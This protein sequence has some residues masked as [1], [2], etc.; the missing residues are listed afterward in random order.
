[1]KRN[2]YL[3]SQ[4]MLLLFV[5]GCMILAPSLGTAQTF[6]FEQLEQK[7]RSFSVII[8]MKMEIAFGVH[9]SEQTERHLGTIVSSDGLVLFDG[10]SLVND[11]ALS[12]F[13]GFSVK[14]TPTH[15]EITTMNDEKFDGEYLGVDRYTKL[16]FIRIKSNGAQFT[17]V[18]FETNYDF[19]VGHWIAL[20]MLLPEFISPNLAADVGMISVVIESPERFPLTVGF[21]ALQTASVLFDE[22]LQPVGVL[23]TLMDPSSATTDA[24]G[25]LESFGQFD[26]PLLGVLPGER[27][28][29]LINDP[30]HQGAIDRGWLGITLQA[31]TKDIA[32]FWGLDIPGGIIVNEIVKGS[33][34]EK[35]GLQV[36]DIVAKVNGQELTID[37]EEKLPVF[38]RMIS[39]MGP[40]T[41]VELFVIRLNDSGFDTL[42]LLI[43]LG[44]A[45][46]SASDA[47]EYENT[48]LEFK[49]RNMVFS[50][51]LRN[52]L[53]PEKF[54][55]VVISNLK[56]GGLAEVGGLRPGDIIQRIDDKEIS[57]IDD[58]SAAMEQ[59]AA[60]NPS[61]VIFFIWRNN[62]TLF[63]NV[64]T[65]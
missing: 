52:N 19:K 29:P 57:S 22:N 31:L 44:E 63:V 30:P 3:F 41:P 43:T 46:I 15:I 45:P 21:S 18:Q 65:D 39:E 33:P 64:K 60:E 42:S 48:F 28:K 20:Y 7:V 50:D 53:D 11:G 23:G 6:D 40:H 17:P 1:M 25:M 5:T 4:Y 27:L 8:D 9:T 24:G 56:M 34:A 49:V 14:T 51:F 55:G 16:A 32:E 61:E 36:G 26:I 59:I 37:K 62:K 13:A 47:K 2:N 58:I 35:G 10:S 38:Q 12:V 54:S